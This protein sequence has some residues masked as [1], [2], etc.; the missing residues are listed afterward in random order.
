MSD[1]SYIK[2]M[3]EKHQI[4]DTFFI[5]IGWTIGECIAR[6]RNGEDLSK[7]EI[8]EMLARAIQVAYE[9]NL[10]GRNMKFKYTAEVQIEVGEEAYDLVDGTPL[11]IEREHAQETLIHALE[12]GKATIQVEQLE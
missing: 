3:I 1:D 4:P 5:A 11:E 7:K 6:Q 10:R 12:E 2:R 9:S 8:P